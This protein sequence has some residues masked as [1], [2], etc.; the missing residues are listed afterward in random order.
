MLFTA[1]NDE[2]ETPVQPATILFNPDLTTFEGEPGAMA[3]T[4]VSVSAPSG[5]I[6]LEVYKTI[7]TGTPQEYEVVN[8]NAGEN[9]LFYDFSY[10]LV[11]AEV[12]ETVVFEFIV[13]EEGTTPDLS[14]TITITTTSPTAR[15]YTATLLYAPLGDKSA[16]SFFSTNTGATYSPDS[17]NATVNP[18]S[19]DVDFG[20]Y[21]GVNDMASLASPFGYSLLP[22]LG[23]QVS[24]W[25]TLNKINFKS[26]TISAE[27]FIGITTYAE[28]DEAYAGGTDEGDV[29]TGLT[30]DKV[31]AFETDVDKS[32]GSKKG[33]LIVKSIS[34]TDGQGDY[35]ELDIVV[36]ESA[37]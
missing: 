30:V 4:K 18:L 23:S 1:C 2:E 26:T 20:Y 16:A 9:Q 32:G 6:A 29:I 36:Q 17:I 19:A 15:S 10:E 11:V 35:I 24:G 34:G 12:G 33:V 37:E 22:G 5:L 3:V 14:K 21:F 8:P 31:F 25:G 13:K 28:I 27:G 7:G